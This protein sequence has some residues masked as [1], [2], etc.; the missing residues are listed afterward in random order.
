LKDFWFRLSLA[1]A[2]EHAGFSA[3]GP[4][5]FLLTEAYVL[6]LKR[7]DIGGERAVQR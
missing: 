5:C 6:T 4:F 7:L 2:L 3:S 1:I